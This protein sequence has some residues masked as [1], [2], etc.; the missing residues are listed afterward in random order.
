MN[1]S[2]ISNLI[3]QLK[4]IH[5]QRLSTGYLGGHLAAQ[6]SKTKRLHAQSLM[7]SG[8]SHAD[9][10]YEVNEAQKLAERIADH[11]HFMAGMG[12]TA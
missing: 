4:K 2:T 12:V 11:E 1:L 10:W 5:A 6:R 8:Y 9:A 7:S 3:P